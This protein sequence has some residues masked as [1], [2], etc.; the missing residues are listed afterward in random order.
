MEES[1]KAENSA[2]HLTML[3]EKRYL[4]HPLLKEKAVEDRLYQNRILERARFNNTLVVLPTALGKTIIALLLAVEKAGEGK[5]FFLAPTRPLIQQHH[6]TFLEKT[7]FG[8]DEL[9][10]VTGRYPPNHRA[11]LYSKARIVFA[12]PQCVW[13]D[14]RSGLLRLDDV[15]L[16][17]F[18]EAHRARGNYAYVGIASRYLR[19]CRK[20]LVLG[21][22]ASP[23]GSEEK[24]AEVCRNLGITAIEHRTDKD[25]DVRPYVQPIEVEWR[26]VKLPEQYLAV[27]ERLRQMLVKRIKG[28]QALGVLTDKQPASITRRDLV[29]LNEELQ[30]RLVGGEGG[31]LY[32]LKVEATAAL[33]IAHM[34]ELIESQGPETLEAFI[35]KSLKRMATE[36]SKGHRSILNDPLF[37]EARMLLRSCMAAENP[38]VKELFKVLEAQLQAKPDSRLIVFTQYRDTV[39]ALVK[40]LSGNPRL[41]VERF[42]GQGERE[43]D[44]GMSQE[45]Q[46]IVLEKLRSGEVN[47]LIATSIAEEGLDIPEVDHVVFYEPV[48]SEIRYIQRRGRTGRRV[49]GKVTIIIAEDTVDEAFYWSSISRAKKMRQIISQLDRKLPEMLKSTAKQVVTLMD[50]Q[51]QT[52]QAGMSTQTLQAQG[53]LPKKELWKPKTLQTKGLS[54]AIRWLMEN[55]PSKTMQ[56]EEVVRRAYEDEGLEKTV[57]ET[58]IWCLIQQGQIYQPEP[59]KIRKV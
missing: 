24:I 2:E 29:E 46:R 16:M 52:K 40:A 28:L 39:N 57:V 21:L 55:L 34:I 49:A 53:A 44:P 4:K 48:P 12:T 37:A 23:G 41:R 36:G 17:I 11:A 27:R 30:R 54:Q 47:V 56:I 18:D 10:L 19:E 32:Q 3:D 26:R 58:A 35:E 43:G 9:A 31:F 25:D 42:V 14:L 51:P 15:S 6:R 13:N 1:K 8:K 38:K 50:Y 7:L 22:T 33:S 45:E 20:P 5:V 59:G